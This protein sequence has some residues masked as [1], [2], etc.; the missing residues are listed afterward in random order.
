[1]DQTQR[2]RFPPALMDLPRHK[3]QGVIPPELFAAIAAAVRQT[4]D[5]YAGPDGLRSDPRTERGAAVA[6]RFEVFASWLAVLF[7][8][9]RPDVARTRQTNPVKKSKGKQQCVPSSAAPSLVAP[10]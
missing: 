9:Q 10:A 7:E 6:L 1:M 2:I 3:A 4:G 5:G 8:L